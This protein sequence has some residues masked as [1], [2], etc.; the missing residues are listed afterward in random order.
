MAAEGQLWLSDDDDDDAIMCEWCN[1]YLLP[2]CIFYCNCPIGSNWPKRR[3]RL[4]RFPLFP[5]LYVGVVV[6]GGNRIGVIQ[7]DCKFYFLS[8]GAKKY[9]KLSSP[10]IFFK[11]I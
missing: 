2:H 8:D 10:M 4:S 7:R 6:T 5:D 9:K 1:K 3:Q 11:E